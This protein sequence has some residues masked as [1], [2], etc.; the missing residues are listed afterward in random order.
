MN[1]A[2]ESER[3]FQG[4]DVEKRGAKSRRALA[5]I[6]NTVIADQAVV[7]LKLSFQDSGINKP[8]D[9]NVLDRE[10]MHR[11]IDDI[12]TRDAENPLMVSTCVAAMYSHFSQL[13]LKFQI[14]PVYMEKQHH[15]NEKMRC[16]LVDWMVRSILSCSRLSP[17]MSLSC[18]FFQNVVHMKFKLLPE[19]LYT[20]VSILDR[21]LQKKQVPRSRLQL[22]GVASLLV[23]CCVCSTL[24]FLY[25]S[26][27]H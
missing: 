19:S 7:P 1:I 10:Y 14:K 23:R 8:K 18:S 4:R 13:E 17:L 2:H 3:P 9:S 5:N 12:D 27:N 16:I 11:P 22:V 6:T 26:K 24:S 21:Y 15:I 25:I 20:C